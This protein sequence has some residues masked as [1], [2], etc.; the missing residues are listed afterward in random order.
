[1]ERADWAEEGRGFQRKQ[2]SKSTEEER[3]YED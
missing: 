3:N 1:M 2:Q